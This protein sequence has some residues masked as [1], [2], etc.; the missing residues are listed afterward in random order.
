MSFSK[1][2]ILIL[3][4]WFS[5]LS[6]EDQDALSNVDK[7]ILSSIQRTKIVKDLDE[8]E[9]INSDE[10]WKSIQTKINQEKIQ[11]KNTIFSLLQPLLKYAAIFIGIGLFFYVYLNKYQYNDTNA[12]IVFNTK[13]RPVILTIDG[14]QTQLL[15]QEEN[16]ILYDENKN[17]IGAIE[18][19]QLTYYSQTSDDDHSIHE[20]KVPHGQSFRVVLSDGTKVYC[21]A[22]TTL[23][24]P[25]KFKKNASRKVSLT[26]QAF[27]DVYKSTEDHFIV[28]TEG[29]SIQVLGTQFNV[30]TYS[31]NKH[32]DVVLVEGVVAVNIPKN[33]QGVTTKKILVPG[34]KAT[35]HQTLKT[36][37]IT[38][39]A[40]YDYT[41]WLSKKMV[42]KGVSFE[43]ILKTL[44][45]KFNVVIKND[46]QALNKHLFRAKFDT[47][48]LTEILDAFKKDM[49]FSYEFKGDI[50]HI[51]AQKK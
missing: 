42:F 48:N 11:P 38:K 21:D 6:T 30:S 22:G 12:E 3:K 45:R 7:Q 26:G 8:M 32:T 9:S 1:T 39:V 46:Y 29:M 50:V 18:G 47:E 27:F 10:A 44:E 5:V 20:L 28:N 37:N 35:Y 17:I 36:L 19:D 43:D 14:K 31:E 16:K 23:K 13:K 34:Q 41:S 4:K 49:P 2:A 25:K 33:R 40:A 24:Y 51:N 15:P